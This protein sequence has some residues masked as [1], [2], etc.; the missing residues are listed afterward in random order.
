[1]LEVAAHNLADDFYN[2]AVNRAYY[3]VFYAA[4][5]LLAT[6]G[7]SRSKHSGVIAA[8]RQ[9]FVKP[10]HIE[11]EYGR[12]YGR[13]MNDRHSGDYDIEFSV[14]PERAQIDLADAQRFVHRMERYLQEERGL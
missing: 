14:G 8:F 5:A 10:E 4:N 12:I 7:L 6:Q 11:S 1:M 2:S 3:V 13:L 9:H